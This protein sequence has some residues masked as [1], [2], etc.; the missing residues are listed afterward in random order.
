LASLLPLAAAATL[1]APGAPASPAA[2]ATLTP[3][4]TA[5]LYLNECAACHGVRLQG[6]Y[7]PALNTAKFTARWTGKEADLAAFIAARMP[8]GRE[9]SLSPAEAGA[10]AAYLLQPEA[11]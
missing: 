4:A 2:P 9:G 8:L 7:G 1:A 11:K 5:A 6:R 10:L 3:K